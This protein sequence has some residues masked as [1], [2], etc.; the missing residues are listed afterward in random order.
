MGKINKMFKQL[1]KLAGDDD[2]SSDDDEV[3]RKRPSTVEND[4]VFNNSEN[5]TRW[6]KAMVAL[7]AM[8]KQVSKVDP[9]G[10]DIVCFGGSRDPHANPSMYRGVKNI[11]DVEK[12]VTSRLPGG[13]CYMGAAM[14]CVLNEAFSRGFK[15]RPCGILVLTAGRPDDSER[16]EKSLKDAATYI[17]KKGYKESP[18]TVTFVH[19]GDDPVA[20]EYMM[21][22]QYNMK[23]INRSKKTHEYVD[24]VD[25][26]N[27]SEIRAAMKEIRG[28]QSSGSTGAVIGAFAGA[29]M[30]VGGV[31]WYNKRQ[32]AKRTKGWNGKWKATYDGGEI[33]T[34][35]VVDDMKGHLTIKGFPGGTTT[36]KYA[37]KKDAYNITFRDADE[38]WIIKGDIDDE[39]TIFW[40][41]GTRWDEIP[42]KGASWKHYAA[43]GA[44]GAATGGAI[45]YLLEKKFFHKCS[46]KDE[47]D[48]VIVVDRSAMMAVKDKNAK[49]INTGVMGKITDGVN[50]M[51]TGDKVAAGILGTAAVAGVAAGGYAVAQAVRKD[52]D[53]AEVGEAQRGGTPRSVPVAVAAPVGG[54]GGGLSGRWRSTFDGDEIAVLM[55]KDDLDG[56]IN[57]K[58]FVGGTTVGTYKKH[59][60]SDRIASIEFMDADEKWPVKGEVKGSKNNV[61]VWDD[62]SRWDRIG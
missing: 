23:S 17:A 46:K 55:V 16:L 49:P 32:A 10:L 54:G 56:C 11:K 37:E 41:D 62:G 40:S 25:T 21:H 39:H 48:Y 42:P 24:I 45:G 29:A 38:Q 61:I 59:S 27:D 51:S 28:T 1:E 33:A 2:D 31:Y 50:N 9:D 47:A 57:I 8:V 30:G 13:P 36:G 12:M 20:E 58:G 7:N 15:K 43:A 44:A 52:D 4:A 35:Q 6:E 3:R 26:V 22:L 34:L 18:L 5:P 60:Q 19:V 14:D 53:D